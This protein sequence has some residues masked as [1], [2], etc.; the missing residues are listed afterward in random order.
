LNWFRQESGGG[1]SRTSS[2]II[3][4][5]ETDEESGVGLD[6]ENLHSLCASSKTSSIKRQ[7]AT[8]CL[9]ADLIDKVGDDHS[10]RHGCAKV[11]L[12]DWRS[13]FNDWCL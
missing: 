13:P 4:A 2:G 12:S 9:E 1:P 10:Q 3:V 11:A 5:F 7:W 8:S 6:H